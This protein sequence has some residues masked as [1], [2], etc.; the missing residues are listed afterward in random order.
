[1]NRYSYSDLQS[2]VATMYRSKPFFMRPFAYPIEFIGVTAGSTST[3]F[4]T[5]QANSDFTLTEITSVVA[6][7]ADLDLVDPLGYMQ[8]TDTGSNERWTSD[9]VPIL[10]YAKDGFNADP[11]YLTMPRFLQGS[12]QL[13]IQ[14]RNDAAVTVNLYLAFRGALSRV[15]SQ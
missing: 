11:F 12:T 6:R 9:F 13:Q 3:Q 15:Y 5:A 8:I 4:M 10:T 7:G 14:F 2:F 1:M